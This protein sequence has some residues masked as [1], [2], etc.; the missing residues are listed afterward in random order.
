MCSSNIRICILHKDLQVW[1]VMCIISLSYCNTQLT[2]Q[3]QS[4][5]VATDHPRLQFNVTRLNCE[6]RLIVTFYKLMRYLRS[7]IH[8]VYLYDLVE[9]LI[10]VLTLWSFNFVKEYGIMFVVNVL[11][12]GQCSPFGHT[13]YLYTTVLPLSGFSILSHVN[14]RYCAALGQ[15]N[16]TVRLVQPQNNAI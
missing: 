12:R 8:T 13:S 2:C 1:S 16:C 6:W 3:L 4:A 11:I 14:N 7:I 5:I 10:E 15:N 9:V